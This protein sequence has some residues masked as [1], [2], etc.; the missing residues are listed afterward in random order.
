MLVA[1][2][3]VALPLLALGAASI[4]L[5]AVTLAAGALTLAC[6][7]WFMSRRG[8]V[9]WLAGFLA[10]AVPALLLL[11][12]A[13]RGLI[14]VAVAAAALWAVALA[15]A[16]AALTGPQP[17]ALPER[18]AVPPRHPYLVMNP[19]SGG[20]TVVRHQLAERARRLG[21]QVG[22]IEGPER[23][24]VAALA[25]AAVARGADL[26]G[27]AGG[28]GTQAL[29]AGVAARHGLP[30]LVISAGTR[31]HFARDLGLAHDDP[32][33]CLDALTDG[34][35]LRVDLGTVAGRPF[36]NN[37][38]FGAYAAMVLDPSYRGGKLR[39]GV[40]A[41]PDALTGAGRV[42]LTV[43]LGDRTV[44]DPGAVLVSN[45][46]YQVNDVAGMTRR[47]RLDA[48]RLGVV[49]V[50]VATAAQAAGLLRGNR[51]RHVVTGTA[52]E[53][54]VEA[55]AERI[56]VAIDGEAV[57]LPAPVHCAIAPGALVVRVPRQRPGPPRT[58]PVVDW[59]RLWRLAWSGRGGD[60]RH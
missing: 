52:T 55:D 34:V 41:L 1:L 11:L 45:N 51:S 14:P 53:I 38:S 16:R 33:A 59:R 28:D 21:A 39:A 18:T 29:V 5:S 43:R 19:R 26:L 58:V 40:A 3:S 42:R 22:L 44:C 15:T 20:G 13:G 48:G 6:G 32:V 8:V 49:A 54:V 31:N 25:S 50:D 24:D 60:D 9:R 36:V 30:F 46:A 2:S 7:W 12:Y 57:W 23:I 47:P 56:P 27:A 17:P 35:D 37:V 4:V 10:L